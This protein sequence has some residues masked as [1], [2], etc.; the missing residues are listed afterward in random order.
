M[1]KKRTQKELRSVARKFAKNFAAKHGIKDRDSVKMIEQSKIDSILYKREYDR[2]RR[3]LIKDAE[4]Y[5]SHSAALD[6]K[7][8][9]LNS[10]HT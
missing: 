4:H 6:R 9:R 8:T 2:V 3:R 1:A 10:S 5:V 7:S